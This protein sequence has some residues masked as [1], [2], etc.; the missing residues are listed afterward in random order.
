[1]GVTWTRCRVSGIGYRGHAASQDFLP[2]FR[3]DQDYY[4]LRNYPDLRV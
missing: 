4:L 1:M 2:S 3:I